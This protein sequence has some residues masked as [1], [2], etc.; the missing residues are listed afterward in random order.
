MGGAFSVVG[1]SPTIHG[2]P[3]LGLSIDIRLE[4]LRSSIYMFSLNVYRKVVTI[5]TTS[6]KSRNPPSTLQ[7]IYCFQ[8]ARREKAKCAKMDIIQS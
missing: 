2:T 4:R 8:M 1:L 3:F 6:F 5:C 7:N